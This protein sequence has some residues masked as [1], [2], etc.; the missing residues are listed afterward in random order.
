MILYYLS[1]AVCRGVH[2]QIPKYVIF[3]FLCVFTLAQLKLFY[4]FSMHYLLKL[5]Q[6]TL[7]PILRLLLRTLRTY[8][9]LISSSKKTKDIFSFCKAR[10]PPFM[11]SAWQ[12]KWAAS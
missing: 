1:P 4:S 12:E 10:H 8:P 2:A 5:T 7:F 3:L 6:K 11:P 9:V